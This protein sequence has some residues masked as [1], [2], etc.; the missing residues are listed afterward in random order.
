MNTTLI[1]AIIAIT[2]ALVFYTTAVFA[3]RKKKT[4]TFKHL[5]LFALGLVFDTIGTT[6][7]STI[8]SATTTNSLHMITGTIAIVLM[9][10]H[11][12]WAIV[13]YYKGNENM[14]ANFHK[15]SLLVWIIWLI[16]YGIGM[17]MGMSR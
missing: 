17:V 3:E 4:L 10:I 16:P 15:F 7:M 9:A 1:F 12:V 2:L 5:I 8:A 14:K 13:V 6:L 11:L